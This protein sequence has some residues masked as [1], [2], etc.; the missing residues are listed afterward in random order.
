MFRFQ[1]SGP[2]GTKNSSNAK[3]DE[4]FQK[5]VLEELIDSGRRAFRGP[6]VMEMSFT[7]TAKNPAAIYT[8]PKHYLDLLQPPLAALNL[9]RRSLL[10]RNDNLLRMLTCYYHLDENTSTSGTPGKVSLT[11]RRLADFLE[12]VRLYFH[13]SEDLHELSKSKSHSGQNGQI[14]RFRK[15]Q[16]ERTCFEHQLGK[17]AADGMDRAMRMLAQQEYLAMCDPSSSE[18][19]RLLDP[20]VLFTQPQDDFLVEATGTWIRDRFNHPFISIDCGER[21]L[22]EGDTKLLRARIQAACLSAKRSNDLLFPLVVPCG[23]TII[24]VPPA[25]DK[26]ID[27]D[28]LARKVLSHVHEILQ[29][30]RTYMSK[31]D[32]ADI[33]LLPPDLQ[34]ALKDT[35]LRKNKFHLTYYRVLTVPRS[36]TDSDKG[37]IR[38][39]LHSAPHMNMPFRDIYTAINAWSEKLTRG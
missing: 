12:D 27:L 15:F 16:L 34:T 29:P 28:N 2:V 3:A 21:P 36:K 4:D 31:Y 11:I 24:H 6:I 22:K 8:L 20:L 39:I 9:R 25:N 10:I 7:S 26:K 33:A 14:E 32:E 38:V 5:H 18:I 35:D 30:P 37:N 17:L 1:W 13:L 23:A 19:G